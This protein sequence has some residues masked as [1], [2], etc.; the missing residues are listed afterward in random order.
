MVK[1]LGREGLG[2]T[3]FGGLRLRVIIVYGRGNEI[4]IQHA[5]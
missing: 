4:Y 2:L 1:S 3:H 5:K